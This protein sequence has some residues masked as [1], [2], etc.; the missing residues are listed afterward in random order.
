MTRRHVTVA[1]NGDAGDE[2]F[3]GYD[4]YVANV[5][6]G[7]TQM[8]PT[9]LRRAVA[10]SATLLPASGRGTLSRARR[11]LG[12]LGETREERYVRWMCHFDRNAMS[13]LCSRDFTATVSRDPYAPLLQAYA[14]SDAPDFVDATLSVDVRHYLPDDLLVKVDIATMAHGLEARSPFIDHELMEFAAALPSSLKLRGTTKKYLLKKVARP[15][16]P[17]EII[18]RPK[19]GFGVP[20]E[21]WFRHELREMAHDVLLS[22]RM[23]ERGYFNMDQVATLLR[24]HVTG[25]RSAHYQLWNL[26]FLELWHREFIDRTPGLT[27]DDRQ[28]DHLLAAAPR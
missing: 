21:P 19:M 1:L 16:L 24:D 6:A 5:L 15:F 11:F 18:D 26:L 17:S 3:A 28:L 8:L 23:R 4:R 27:R 25:R 9:A 14:D 13:G 12:A 2:N 22:E 10:R 7:P 20:L